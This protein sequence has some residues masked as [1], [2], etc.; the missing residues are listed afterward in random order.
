MVGEFKIVHLG[1]R[2]QFANMDAYTEEITKQLGAAN[3]QNASNKLVIP[4]D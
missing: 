3:K 4:V 1:E 2:D